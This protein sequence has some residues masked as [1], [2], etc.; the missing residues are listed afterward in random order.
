[1]F[2]R[3]PANRPAATAERSSA[4]QVRGPSTSRKSLRVAAMLP[5]REPPSYSLNSPSMAR[6]TSSATDSTP[7]FLKTFMPAVFDGPHTQVQLLRD[8]FVRLAL[9]DQVHYGPL[10][11]CEH[12]GPFSNLAA[13]MVLGTGGGLLRQGFPDSIPQLFFVVGLFQQRQAPALIARTV[14]RVRG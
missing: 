8:E 11:R 5:S 4:T 7:I 9:D 10:D 14:E 13:A 6:Q 3:V 2:Y 1:M 12:R